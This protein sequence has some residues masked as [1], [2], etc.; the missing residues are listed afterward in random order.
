MW[1]YWC[2]QILCEPWWGCLHTMCNNLVLN[3]GWRCVRCQ[4]SFIE[5]NLLNHPSSTVPDQTQYTMFSTAGWKKSPFWVS[6][7]VEA[8]AALR[9]HFHCSWL[10]ILL[11]RST[12]EC[13][14]LGFLRDIMFYSTSDAI[15]V[16]P[17]WAA[18]QRGNKCLCS[19]W[20]RLVAGSWRRG[21]NSREP[22]KRRSVRH[23]S[24][25]NKT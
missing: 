16:R 14:R 1:T 13:S 10:R 3:L 7:R 23:H 2:V 19:P 20:E 17:C 9:V 4:V 24:S 21:E 12:Q 11:P 8:G 5:Y 15:S 25:N 22:E 18:M 6:P